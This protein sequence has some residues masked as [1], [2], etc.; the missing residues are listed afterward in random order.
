MRQGRKSPELFADCESGAKFLI[1]CVPLNRDYGSRGEPKGGSGC[2]VLFGFFFAAMGGVFCFLIAKDLFHTARTHQWPKVAAR[3]ERSGIERSNGDRND[4]YEVV[5]GFVYSAEGREFHSSQVST[6]PKRFGNYSKAQRLLDGLK[7]ER[8]L[9]AWYN[10]QQ[11]SE[12]ILLQPSYASGL[13]I[14]FPAIFVVIG[15]VLMWAA[16]QGKAGPRAKDGGAVRKK[17]NL[18]GIYVFFGIFFLVGSILPGFM[19]GVPL[20][21]IERAKNWAKV[22]CRIE[23]SNVLRHRGDKTDTY[24][25][26]IL[27]AYEVGGKGYKSNRYKFMGGS[28]SG[29]SSKRE[30]VDRY[31]P[32]LE[33]VCFVNPDDPYD[34]VLNRGFTRDIWFGLFPLIFLIVGSVGLAVTIKNRESKKLL[35]EEV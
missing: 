11:P 34:A 7:G 31:P 22:P 14:F 29:Q 23:S 5:I 20:W 17:P 9:T 24:S 15:C 18:W 16:I 10:P 3:I 13:L 19:M 33:T 32:G 2:L 21:R 8:E 6:H 25:V 28:S 1:F 27:Y 26:D 30:I 12:A 4:P 35:G